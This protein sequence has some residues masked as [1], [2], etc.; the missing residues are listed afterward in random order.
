MFFEIYDRV[1]RVAEKHSGPGKKFTPS[2]FTN[3]IR[4]QFAGADFVFKTIKDPAVDPDMIIV[5]G[6]YDPMEDSLGDPS[7][8]LALC[9]CPGQK[10]YFIDLIDWEK[11]CFDIAECLCHEGIHQIQYR[12]QRSQREFTAKLE[13]TDVHHD[14]EYLANDLELEAYGFSIAAESVMFMQHFTQCSMYKVYE[15]TFDNAPTIMSKLE[16]HILKYLKYL[17]MTYDQASASVRT[18]RIRYR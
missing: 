4:R 11:L 16:Q 15:R 5:A 2:E 14:P 6:S 1:A 13:E 7:I 9:Y 12:K 10:Y 3:L 18:T 17:E 8:E